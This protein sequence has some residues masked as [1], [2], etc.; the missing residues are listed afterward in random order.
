MKKIIGLILAIIMGILLVSCGETKKELNN[1]I[2]DGTLT[3]TENK[4]QAV[5]EFTHPIL[6]ELF[7]FQKH[8]ITAEFVKGDEILY[9]FVAD[10]PNFNMND[11]GLISIY[12]NDEGN[13]STVNHSIDKTTIEWICTDVFFDPTIA[14]K[15]VVKVADE[16][17]GEIIYDYNEEFMVTDVFIEYDGEK[18]IV[19]NTD[20]NIDI[21]SLL[22]DTTETKT[23]I[24]KSLQDSWYS[25]TEIT[26]LSQ[27]AAYNLM[28]MDTTFISDELI[29][30]FRSPSGWILEDDMTVILKEDNG[31]F[32]GYMPEFISKTGITTVDVT[33]TLKV[34]E[35]RLIL[36]RTDKPASF[37]SD[38]KTDT[39]ERE[40]VA[41]LVN[42]KVN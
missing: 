29:L 4:N 22:K 34:D 15:I 33:I 23:W 10:Y 25:S 19:I 37:Y 5:I 30:E 18:D 20:E 41:I 13:K 3:I 42:G 12:T 40:T 6:D 11:W 16:I 39:G 28:I 2:N 32:T 35:N 14:D 38:D 8:S 27:N 1:T 21:L 31:V 7:K 36:T 26:D 9:S 24:S 17:E